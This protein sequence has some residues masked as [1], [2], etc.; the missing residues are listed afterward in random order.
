MGPQIHLEVEREANL[1][2]KQPTVRENDRYLPVMLFV[3]AL[4]TLSSLHGWCLLREV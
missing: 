4:G 1:G 3:V 2:L